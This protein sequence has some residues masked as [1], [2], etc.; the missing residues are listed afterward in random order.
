MVDKN[1]LPQGE[2]R[3]GDT[4]QSP[5]Y[6]SVTETDHYTDSEYLRAHCENI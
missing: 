3:L 4:Y 5:F 6:S 2:T 1:G